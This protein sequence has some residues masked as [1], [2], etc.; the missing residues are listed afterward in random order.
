MLR[1][2]VYH[3]LLILSAAWF[4]F[5]CSAETTGGGG[6]VPAQGGDGRR[7][8]GGGLLISNL[9]AD[10][11]VEVAC[12][13][14]RNGV[15]PTRFGPLPPQMAA[16]CDWNMRMFDLGATACIEKS[17]EAAV[18]ALL[19]DPLTAAV[20]TPAQIKQMATELFDAEAEFLEGY[21]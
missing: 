9:P 20:C 10:G 14:D 13:I 12:M 7:S 15:Q 1:P 16:V 3:V 5:A 8:D 11:C 6:F 2:V 4:G 18:H 19:L 17:K 21:E